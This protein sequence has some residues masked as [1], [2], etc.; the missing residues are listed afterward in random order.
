MP[1]P[2]NHHN[3]RRPGQR[4]RADR[5][6]RVTGDP[7]VMPEPTNRR[8]ERRLGQR[9]RADRSSWVTG[10]P[11]AMPEPTN[12]R[13]ERRLGQRIRANRSPWSFAVVALGGRFAVRKSIGLFTVQWWNAVLQPPAS[14]LPLS[15]I[16]VGPRLDPKA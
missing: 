4:I 14:L 11:S 13:N 12:R 16:G 3:E 8:N 5:S 15:Y 6:P 7:S 2:I 1:E 9:I 10:D